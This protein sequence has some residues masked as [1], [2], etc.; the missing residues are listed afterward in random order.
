M[1]DKFHVEH[2]LHEAV[3]EVRKAELWRQ[4][5]RMR[6][7]VRGKKWLL[8]RRRSRVHWRRRRILDQM[9]ALNR[10]LQKAY[11]MKEWF[12][13]NTNPRGIRGTIHDAIEGADLFLGVSAPKVITGD[14][15]ETVRKC[16]NSSGTSK[17]GCTVAANG[18]RPSRRSASAVKCARNASTCSFA[19]VNPAAARCPPKRMRWVEAVAMAS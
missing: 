15:A 12:A 18:G 7:L 4:G 19:M 13:E 11:V 9:L 8:L 3:N 14:N 17:S 5:G 16:T 2:H 10:R 1:F 6:D